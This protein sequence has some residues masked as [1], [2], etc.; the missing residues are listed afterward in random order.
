MVAILHQT[1]SHNEQRP[2]LGAH[3]GEPPTSRM[4]K[5][6]ILLYLKQK[7]LAF[8]VMTAGGLSWSPIGVEYAVASHTVKRRPCDSIIS[9]GLISLSHRVNQSLMKVEGICLECY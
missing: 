9:H 7:F 2:Q 3:Q 4:A 8:G 1:L 6:Q 5:R